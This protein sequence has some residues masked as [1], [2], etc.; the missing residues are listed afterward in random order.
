MP[1]RGVAAV[2]GQLTAGESYV[3]GRPGRSATC[4]MFAVPAA[5]HIW[6]FGAS[7]AMVNF[8]PWT[9]ACA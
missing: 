7:C 5:S 8:M 2:C 6:Y 1:G 4:V 9:C 3:L